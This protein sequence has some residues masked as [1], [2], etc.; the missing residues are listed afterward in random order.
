MQYTKAN[1]LKMKK[2]GASLRPGYIGASE[3]TEAEKSANKGGGGSVLRER[4]A[5]KTTTKLHV[6]FNGKILR[7]KS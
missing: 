5:E 6:H 4:L 2:L 3:V 1:G 7:G